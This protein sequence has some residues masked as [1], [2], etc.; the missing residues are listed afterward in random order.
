MRDLYDVWPLPFYCSFLMPSLALTGGSSVTGDP[1]VRFDFR[2]RLPVVWVCCLFPS[3]IT[4]AKSAK[5]LLG[6]TL[7]RPKERKRWKA[8]SSVMQNRFRAPVGY[9]R[10]KGTPQLPSPLSRKGLA[11][12]RRPSYKIA[13]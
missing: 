13:I 3:S 6:S 9:S 12:S 4:T 8:T 10:A 5:A 1:I 11:S 2:S 7:V